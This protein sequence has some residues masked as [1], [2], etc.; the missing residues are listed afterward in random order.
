MLTDAINIKNAFVINFNIEF[1]ITV[2][3]NYNNEETLLSC[4][5]EIKDYFLIDKWQINQ[6]I[7]ISEVQ[8][9]IGSVRGVQTVESLIFNNK[10]GNVSGY[11]QYKYNFNKATKDGIIYP[12]MDPSIFELKYPNRDIN[13]RVTTY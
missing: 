10:S 6:P 4:I 9:L 7:S 8:N 3:K 2:F 13:G 11:S 1:E 5:S 12:S